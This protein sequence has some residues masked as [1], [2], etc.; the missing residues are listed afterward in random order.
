[1][2][3]NYRVLAIPAALVSCAVAAFAQETS[4][5]NF[6]LLI[7]IYC[8]A[9]QVLS[10]LNSVNDFATSAVSFPRFFS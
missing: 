1:M 4:G 3:R 7:A 8:N 9:V 2:N 10:G 5:D 6:C